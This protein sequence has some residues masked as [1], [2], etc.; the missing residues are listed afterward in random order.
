VKTINGNVTLSGKV[1]DYDTEKR[2]ISTVRSIKSVNEVKSKLEIDKSV[3]SLKGLTS[4]NAILVAIKLKYFE[5]EK[6]NAADLHVKIINREVTLTGVVSDQGSK[7][8]AIAIASATN[9][10]KKVISNLNVKDN[11]S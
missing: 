3:R 7:E 1:P 9:G 2:L 4:D 11:L 5:D 8:R 10:V 6:L